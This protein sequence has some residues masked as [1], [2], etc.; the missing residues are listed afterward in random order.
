MVHVDAS[1]D[2]LPDR[3]VIGQA[4]KV[5]A[6]SL[7]LVGTRHRRASQNVVGATAGA[8]LEPLAPVLTPAMQ[9]NNMSGAVRPG[10]HFN[11]TSGPVEQ[12]QFR[13]LAGNLVA[14]KCLQIENLR[15]RRVGVDL[16]F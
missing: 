6:P 3:Y 9:D 8:A 11:D 13:R 15:G 5:G 1:R 10:S 16:S 4:T 2:D 7:R 12:R 14:D